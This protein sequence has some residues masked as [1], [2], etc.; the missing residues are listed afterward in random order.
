VASGTFTNDD[1]GRLND[2]Q[3]TVA[4]PAVQYVRLTIT[5][6]QTPDF[7]TSCP[8]GGYSGCSYTDFTELEVLGAVAP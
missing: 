4:E 2:V 8:G 5:S 3:P 7:A 6:N 1:V